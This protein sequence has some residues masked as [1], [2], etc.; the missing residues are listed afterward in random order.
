MSLV[1]KFLKLTAVVGVLVS[2]LSM[3][4]FAGL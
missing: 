4:A 2:L 1:S 3:P